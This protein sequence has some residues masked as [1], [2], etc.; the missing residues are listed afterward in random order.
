[1]FSL[2]HSSSVLGVEGKA[3]S[4]EVDIASGLPQISVVGLPDPA[5][6]ESVER[7]RAAIKN[8]GFTFPLDRI[9]VNLAPADL[10]KEGTAFDLA[11]AAGILTASGQ[12]EAKPFEQSMLIGE[13]SL[14]G[15]I[16][17]VPG[18]LAMIEQAKRSGI[19]KVLLPLANAKEAAWITE[20]ELYA[21]TH[22]KELLTQNKDAEAW[23]AIRF[24][25]AASRAL[26]SAAAAAEHAVDFGDYSDVYGQQQAKRALLIA[27]AGKHNIL[28]AGP[29]GTG[30]TMMIRRLPGILPPLTEEEAL[31]VTKIYSAA[32]KLSTDAKG[33]I[34]IAP[35]R[36]PHHTISA[37][38]LIGGGS[39]PK[40]G[41]VTLAHHGVLYLDELPEF[42]R[43]VL[44]VLRQPLED[45]I[46]T[47]ARSRA[48]FH[49]PARLMLAV[50]FNPCPCGYAGHE[51]AEKR[52][53]CSDSAIAKYK[54]KMSG[55]LLDRIDIQLEVP[56][57]LE[58]AGDPASPADMTTA[59]M[60]QLVLEARARKERRDEELG[61]TKTPA[62]LS[63]KAL[64]R[65][66]LMKNEAFE[67]LDQAL[68]VLNIS[69]RAYDR[70]LRLARTIADVEGS[71]YV[72]DV[73]VAEAIQYR[74]LDL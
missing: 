47:I 20:M 30:K 58:P 46:V 7:V 23:S 3:I 11:I 59:R 6:R 4:V 48:V 29:P 35:F 66:I 18:V 22:L 72:E 25:A 67:L 63:G 24:D 65:S 9:T 39:V 15:D 17:P 5:V 50:S 27:A 56:R 68:T 61:L 12:L 41:E 13:L 60:R 42:S 49:F 31:E 51:T 53:T 26:A 16:R 54:S 45:G 44:E 2:M 37:G 28:F 69:M 74:R 40:P 70:I 52:C 19:R 10:R 8:S 34:R 55:P 36:S 43:A 1:M 14:N 71:E 57:P 33:L 62:R 64:R 21:V 32:G 73:H 38:G